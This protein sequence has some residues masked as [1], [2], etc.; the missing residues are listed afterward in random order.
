MHLDRAKELCDISV[1]GYEWGEF[2]TGVRAGTTVLPTG[3]REFYRHSVRNGWI[4]FG[5]LGFLG[6]L[7]EL[8][9]YP[10]T[11]RCLLDCVTLL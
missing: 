1:S 10:G 2:Q 7:K 6:F 11:R 9:R 3:L 8:N 5:F 4:L